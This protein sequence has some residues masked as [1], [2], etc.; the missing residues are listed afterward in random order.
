[1]SKKLKFRVISGSYTICKFAAADPIP[2]WATE[3]SFTSITRTADELSIVCRAENVPEERL[4]TLWNCLKI[5]GPFAFSEVGILYAFIQP[6]AEAGISVFAIATYDT[7]YVL[8][9]QHSA[10]EA[11]RVLQ[12]AGH[13]LVAT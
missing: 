12:D 10:Y 8:I 11:I 3:G 5:E 13:E 6:L 1:L 4:E 7:D 9:Q 2:Q